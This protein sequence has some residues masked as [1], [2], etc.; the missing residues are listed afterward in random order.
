MTQTSLLPAHCR[1]CGSP[2][3]WSIVARSGRRIPLDPA[4]A[5][6]R[7]T[8][9]AHN[10]ETGR[11]RILTNDDLQYVDGWVRN[12]VTVHRAHFGTCPQQARWSATTGEP[13]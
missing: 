8:H 3:I 10:P 11:C 1:S 5:Q 2:V 13:A 9:V 6:P 7:A 4:P 12:G